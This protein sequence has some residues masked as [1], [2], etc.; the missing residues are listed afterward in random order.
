MKQ[1]DTKFKLK[2]TLCLAIAEWF[3]TEH[4]PLWKYL[5]KFQDAI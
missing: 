3:K 5:E 4:V 2:E 1:L